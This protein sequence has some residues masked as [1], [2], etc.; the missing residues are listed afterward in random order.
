MFNQSD[1]PRVFGLAPGVDFPAALVQGLQARLE[2]SPPDA[3]ARVDLIVN[4][5]RMARRLRD[6]FDNGAPGFLPRVRLV[7]D[8]DTLVPGITLPPATSSLRRRLEL[9]QLVSKLITADP[10]LA[11]RSSLYALSD[12]LANLIDEMQGEGVAASAVAELDVSDQS[13]HW[14]RAQRFLTIAQNYLNQTQGQPDKEAR[15][16]QLV[17]R[18]IAHWEVKPPANPVILAGSTG[19]R[20]TTSMLMQ[21]VAK[22][23]QGAIIL[24]GFDFDLPTKVWAALDQEL[25]SEDH[26]QYRFGHI[27]RALDLPRA[28]IEEWTPTKPPSPDRNALISLSLRPAPVT[29][30]WLTEGP[31]LKGL[32]T[33]TANLTLVEAPTP[34]IEALAIALRL[35]KAVEEGKTAALIT[36]DRMLTR[37]VTSALDRWDILPDDSAGTPLQLSPPGRFLRHVAA[38]FVRRLD[39]EALLTLLKHPLTHSDAD[40]NEHQLNTQRLDMQIR[41]DGLP[42]VDADGL[43]RIAAKAADKQS[44]PADFL[45][46]ADWVAATFTAHDGKGDKTLTEWVADHLKLANA[47]AAGR[48]KTVDNELWNRKAGQKAQ[49]VMADLAAQAEYGGEMT[50]SDYADLVGALLATGEVRDR[51]APHPDIMIWGTLEARVQGADLVI[52]G[53][54]NDGTWPEAPPPDPWLN[55]QMRL[56]VGLLL[57]ERR[58]GL[59]AHDYQQAIAAPEVWLTRAIRS[60]EAETVPSRWLNRLG[61]LLNGLPKNGGPDAWEAMQARGAK[62]LDQVRALEAIQRTPAAIR[63]SPRPPRSAR[64]HGLSVTE[65][66]RLIRD[67]YAIY[68]KHTLRLRTVNPLVQSPDA[69]VRGIVLHEVMERFVKSISAD[70]ARL[71]KERL[72]EI[73]AEVLAVEAPWPAARLMWMARIER[74]ADWFIENEK[75]RQSYSSPVAFE[76][77]ARGTH[78]FADLGFTLTGYADRID[79]TN[80]GDALIYDY[81]TGTPPSKKEQRVFDKQLLIE[82][83]MVEEGGFKEVGTV[84]VAH[85][86]FIGLGAKPVEIAAPLDEEPPVEVLRGLHELISKYL[87]E[88]QGFTARRIV[89]IEEAAGDYDQLARFGEWDGTTKPTPEDLK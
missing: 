31:K 55:R 10:T 68:A 13:G 14:E 28:G 12:S 84:S 22:L 52:M 63:P 47:V 82:A 32:E 78:V 50:A 30:A 54:L 6:I 39:A 58:I 36:P 26:P 65:I 85:A 21:A 43:S 17:K 53:G 81:K 71:T 46:W 79:V 44:G 75:R 2:G 20:G 74:F 40:R 51:D 42:Y 1:R 45:A 57:P 59:S 8:L 38:L 24:P 33:A 62:W 66:K 34:R 29:H 5:N 4:T 37:Q 27:M 41:R 18:I 60:D 70:P 49:D 69:P 9:V 80:D 88:T 15:Q 19:S 3:M 73:A 61:N 76:K 86:A 16:R 89:K 48:S 64:P 67:P 11:P 77:G 25:L 87:D 7:T 35:R 56:K 72:L 83:A 23:P